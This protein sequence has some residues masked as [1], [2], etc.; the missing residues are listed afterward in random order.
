M[1]LF[2]FDTRFDVYGRQ[3][4]HYDYNKPTNFRLAPELEGKVDMIVVDPPFLSEE[5][6]EKTIETVKYLLKPEGKLILCTGLSWPDLKNH[7]LP[8]RSPKRTLERLQ[9]L[10]Q[11]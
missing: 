1:F 10:Y 9:M 7:R 2:E 4:I 6:L 3:F 11:L 5:C 8:P